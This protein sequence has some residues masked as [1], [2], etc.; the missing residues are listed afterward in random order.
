[1]VSPSTTPPFCA[2]VDLD[3][4]SLTYLSCPFCSKPLSTSLPHCPPCSR[5][6]RVPPTPTRL[7]RLLLSVATSDEVT[8]VVCFDR[9][10]RVLMGCSADEFVGF[11]LGGEKAR[12]L[13][14]GEMCVMGFKSARSGNAEHLRVVSVQPLRTGFRPVVDSLRGMHS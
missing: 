7:F 9:A 4:T 1:M 5:N 13:L 8:T 10:A 11:P 12:E 2:I 14:R 6:N 3:T